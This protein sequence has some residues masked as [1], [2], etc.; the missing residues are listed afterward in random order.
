MAK[1]NLLFVGPWPPPFG[2]IASNLYVLLP[3]IKI[4]GYN[5]TT[6]SYTESVD[7]ISK[8][9]MGVNNIYFSP[10]SFFKRNTFSVLGNAIRGLKH[11]KGLSVKRFIRAVTIAER[12]NEI[13]EQ[14]D[15]SFIFTYDNDQLHLSPFIKRK[16]KSPRIFCSIYGAFFLTPDIYLKEKKFLRHAVRHT[17]K[18]LSCSRYCA[19]SG[20]EFLGIDY[21]TKVIYNNVDEILFN[22]KND[23]H[24][25]R[26]KYNIPENAIVL[27]TMGRI[28][29]DMGIDF[30]IREIDGITSIDKN[31]IVF[32]VG[33]RAELCDS[34]ELLAKS[35]SQVRFAFSIPIEE[36]HYFFAA[37]DIFT[38]PT[39]DKHACMGIANIEAMMSGKAVIASRSGGHPETIEDNVSGILVPFEN[40]KLS[41]EF[42]IEKLNILVKNPQ[43]RNEYGEQGRKRALKLFT[44]DQIVEEHLDIIREFS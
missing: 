6:L 1:Y 13:V 33:A 7:E 25:I 26:E 19:D 2:G 18:I 39:K 31:L 36:K 38:A 24:N 35:N 5:V 43:I 44:N 40:G 9:E 11:Q 10:V 14:E 22:P 32:F 17:D 34:V 21:P 16:N 8:Q 15:I 41:A 12:I 3:A 30:L 20:K 29:V 42:Y 28:G 23:G 4:K 37:C 27:M